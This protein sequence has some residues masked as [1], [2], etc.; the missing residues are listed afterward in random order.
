MP[1]AEPDGGVGDVFIVGF[2]NAQA[3]VAVRRVSR[4][5]DPDLRYYGVEFVSLER[6][7]EGAVYEV[8]GRR[9]ADDPTL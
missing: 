9:R 7:F 3:V 1:P 5:D 6:A 8:I 2:D 4:T